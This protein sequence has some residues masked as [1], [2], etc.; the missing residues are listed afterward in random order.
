[1]RDIKVGLSI[2]RHDISFLYKEEI[3]LIGLFICEE[4]GSAAVA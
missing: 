3:S 2:R 1:M 4:M